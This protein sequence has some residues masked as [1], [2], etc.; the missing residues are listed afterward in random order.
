MIRLTLA[1]GAVLGALLAGGCSSSTPQLNLTAGVI[2][3]EDLDPGFHA[4]L[5][6]DTAVAWTD[7]RGGG[8][9]LG[10]RLTYSTASGDEGPTIDDPP[11]SEERFTDLTLVS[12]Q[13]LA[14]Y[15]H[16]FGDP[17]DG[18]AG[19]VEPG[20][21]VGPGVADYES[22]LD[23]QSF[24]EG[25]VA[26]FT[27]NPFVRGGI[28]RGRATLGMELGYQG[29]AILDLFGDNTEARGPYVGLFVAFGLG[30]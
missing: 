6:M 9:R 30:R 7:D 21:G 27:L 19:F 25:N 13:F 23:L 20:I 29:T 16:V 5:G 17:A 12:L 2:D 11:E 8:L 15:R 3:I 22:V 1:L 4:A 26:T 18:V 24:E 10:G 14:S 28:V